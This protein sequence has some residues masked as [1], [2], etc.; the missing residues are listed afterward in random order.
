MKLIKFP[1]VFV[2]F[3]ILK[4]RRMTKIEHKE[5]RILMSL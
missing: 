1:I 2:C 3:F 5:K 4:D